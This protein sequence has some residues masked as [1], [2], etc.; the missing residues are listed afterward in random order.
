[1]NVIYLRAE[2]VPSPTF[3]MV[4]SV[5]WA[6]LIIY[7]MVADARYRRKVLCFDFVFLCYVLFPLTVLWYCFWSRGW[8]G[9]LTLL[10]LVLLFCVPYIIA[11]IVWN[12]QYGPV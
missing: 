8:R 4:T 9:I 5:S 11:I 1:M 12:L 6:F 10:G 2:I 3:E 7:W